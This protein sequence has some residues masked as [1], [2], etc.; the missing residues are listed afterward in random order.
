MDTAQW[1]QPM[2][3]IVSTTC[4]RPLMGEESKASKRAGSELPQTCR[5]YWTEG[6]SLRNVP[7]GGGT[8]KNKRP[9][10]SS[11]AN[12]KKTSD[13]TSPSS[14]LPSS[15]N[16][17]FHQG[18]DLNLAYRTNNG[19]HNLS[20]FAQLPSGE[21]HHNPSSTSFSELLR[22]G[23]SSRGLAS[24][25]PMPVLDPNSEY[26]SGFGFHDLRPTLNFPLEGLVGGWRVMVEKEEIWSLF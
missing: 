14:S 23:I 21:N 3:Q 1:P 17:K 13:L 11:S 16:P 24:F 22:S 8:R 18:Q 19:F 20:G 2:E 25:M 6:G 12:S 10:S 9:S 5:R 4:S 7:V 15:Q 26:P